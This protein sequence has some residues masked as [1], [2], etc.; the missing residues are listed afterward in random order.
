MTVAVSPAAGSCLA[1]GRP[2]RPSCDVRLMVHGLMYR[3]KTGRGGF[4]QP[5]L[6]VGR[7]GMVTS[8]VGDNKGIG[9]GY[10]MH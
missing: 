9:S 8:T 3:A 4:C 2:S 5:R 6:A 1:S 7:R 10:C